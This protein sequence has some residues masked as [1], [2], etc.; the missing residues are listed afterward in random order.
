MCVGRWRFG[1]PSSALKP[2]TTTGARHA[3]LL[4][5]WEGTAIGHRT[6]RGLG[7]K[8]GKE[9]VGRDCREA[10]GSGD[11][12]QVFSVPSSPNGERSHWLRRL[13]P[14][15]ILRQTRHGII[16]LSVTDPTQTRR[17]EHLSKQHGSEP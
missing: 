12:V 3:A 4:Q 11:Q 14:Y 2:A 6:C 13:S 16:S 7:K 1:P 9:A 8:P 5:P 10:L 17:D 15:R